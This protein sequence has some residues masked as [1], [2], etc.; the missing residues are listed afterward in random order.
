[1]SNTKPIDCSGS[2]YAYPLLIKQ[3]LHTPLSVCPDQQ[4]VYRDQVRHSYRTLRH[5]IGQLAG[6][7]QSLGIEPGDTVAVMDWDSH[8]YLES[9]FAVPMMGAVLM[10]VNIRLTPDQIAYTLNHSGAKALLIHTDFLP[11]FN[12]LRNGL[13]TVQKL[14]LLDDAG[15]A[16]LPS[17]FMADYESLLAASDPDFAF[18]DFDENT[19][20]TTF[21]TTRTTGLP[22]GVYFSHRQLVLHTLATTAALASAAQ[23]GRVHRED[24]YMPMTPMFHVHAWGMPYVATMLGLKQVYP[25]RYAPELLLELIRREGVSFSHC[26]PTILHMLLSS[27]A[28]A[29]TD[30][31]GW[32]VIIGGSA[33]PSGLARHAI[34]RGIDVYT[35]YGM[36]ETCPILTLSQVKP[37]L[38]GDPEKELSIRTMTGLPIPLVDLRI[39]D[40]NMHDLPHDGLSAGEI[41]VRAPWLTQAY[42]N[43]P[44]ASENLWAGGYLHT[45]DIGVIDNEGY[46]KVTDRLKDVIKSGGEWVSSL[47]IENLLSRHPSVGEVAVIGIKDAKWGERPLPLI[48]LRAGAKVAEMEL[49]KHLMELSIRGT[50]SKFA[51]PERILFVDAIDKTSVG[52]INKKALRDKYQLD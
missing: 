2:A 51:V 49:L 12:S 15:T 45:N 32:K 25:G 8:R 30:L 29:Q 42:V 50:I 1:M 7:L 31:R 17:G 21:Y 9:Y 39:V 4:I 22:K 26:V 5:R 33:L 19:R 37:S 40:D 23:Q 18:Q 3:L 34:E 6:G 11:A 52:K 48:V 14:I 36:S 20:A 10:T 41:V 27:D 44:E 47:E 16:S 24:V 38:A 46:L 43:N 28:A 13:T 35:G